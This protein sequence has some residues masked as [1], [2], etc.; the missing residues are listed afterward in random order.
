[1]VMRRDW[2]SRVGVMYAVGCVGLAAVTAYLE[3]PPPVV[4]HF[5]LLVTFPT[6]FLAA[7]VHHA[8]AMIAFGPEQDGALARN[9]YF[10]WW[11]LVVATQYLGIRL[12]REARKA[13]GA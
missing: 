8:L 11:V 10:A 2:W 9:A 12:V 13:D 7:P 1:M 6:S 4:Y 5:L 3:E